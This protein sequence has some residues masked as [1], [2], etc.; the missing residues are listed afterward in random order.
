MAVQRQL[1]LAAASTDPLI[2]FSRIDT[3]SNRY[4]PEGNDMAYRATAIPI[5]IASPGDV[6]EEREAARDGLHTWNYI[7]SLREKVVLMPVGWETHSSP[8]LGERPQKLTN[9]RVLKECDLLVGIFWTR[10]GTPTGASI[11]GTVEEIERHIAE[12]KPVMLYFSSRPVAPEMLDPD[13]YAALKEFKNKSKNMGLIEE[14][15]NFPEFKEKF[16]RQLALCLQ[17]N[18]HLR[19]ILS[20]QPESNTP[21]ETVPPADIRTLL[22]AETKQL[23]KEASKDPGGVIMKISVMGG[24]FIQTNRK[25]FGGDRGRE[26]AKWEYALDQLVNNG[27][28]TP[29]GNKGE[30]FELSHEGYKLADTLPDY[31]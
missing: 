2:F 24:R 20:D 4:R 14:Y 23:L 15:E 11:S 17:S 10:L 18:P 12:G 19:K 21:A 26:S 1:E 5:M 13:Q 8:E 16:S 25:G 29:K 9:D 27:Y 30:I 7:N 22:S 28:V 31:E 3:S 6:L